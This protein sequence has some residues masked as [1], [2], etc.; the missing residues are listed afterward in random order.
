M[1]KKIRFDQTVFDIC[2]AYPETAEIMARLGFTSISQPGML[3]TLGRF[4][5]LKK[6][7]DLKKISPLSIRTAFEAGGF[8]IEGARP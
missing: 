8:S 6:G 2:A 3:Q 4:V 1:E 5:T 7:S